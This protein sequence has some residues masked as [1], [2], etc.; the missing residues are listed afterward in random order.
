MFAKK[1]KTV[2]EI[3]DIFS[4]MK[5][6][7]EQIVLDQLELREGFRAQIRELEKAEDSAIAEQH[8]AANAIEKISALIE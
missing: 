8:R 6:D 5:K 1:R 4:R 3:L 2:A 7:L